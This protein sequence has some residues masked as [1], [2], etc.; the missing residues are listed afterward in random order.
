MAELMTWMGTGLDAAVLLLL[1]IVLWRLRGDPS[2]EWDTREAGLRG[3]VEELRTLIAEAERQA[4][5][6]DERLAA[7][8]A[9][10]RGLV[11]AARPA[12]PAAPSAPRQPVSERVREL[13]AH[14]TPIEEI[15]RRLDLPLAEAR[16]LVGLEQAGRTRAGGGKNEPATSAARAHTDGMDDGGERRRGAGMGVALTR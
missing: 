9:E 2:A 12:R 6:L 4:R 3:T 11:Q 13:A 10:L 7:H 15:A 5:V 1:A 16:L 8:A 14:A